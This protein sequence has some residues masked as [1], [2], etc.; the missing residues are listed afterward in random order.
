[1]FI[2]KLIPIYWRLLLRNYLIT[3]VFF[4]AG[5]IALFFLLSAKDLLL[6]ISHGGSL[7]DNFLFALYQIPLALP[8]S[9]PFSF[10][11]SS[12]MVVYKGIDS[13][14]F[15]AFRSLGLSFTK[16]FAPL[17]VLFAFVFLCSLLL[18]SEA[19]PMA[20]E[21]SKKMVYENT[22]KYPLLM[23][24]RKD[25]LIY[26]DLNI[27]LEN[28]GQNRAKDLLV[29]HRDPKKNRLTLFQ[30]KK[31]TTD[32]KS[33]SGEN[34]SVISYLL[35]ENSPPMLF[36]ENEQKMGIDKAAFSKKLQKSKM[37]KSLS[38]LPMRSLLIK[39]KAD[40]C[41]IFSINLEIMYRFSLAL[42]A[43]SF[44]L[45]GL[46]TSLFPFKRQCFIVASLC[47]ITLLTHFCAKHVSHNLFICA[48]F[49]FI[50]SLSL[51]LYSSYSFWKNSRRFG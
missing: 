36:I 32:E 13:Q 9:L 48:I 35:K 45:L 19:A 33:L 15:T 5:F 10:L 28:E 51:I 11:F 47:F 31:L 21:K 24:K 38:T 8:L 3:F 17:F 27:S 34:L 14:E 46:T 23:L 37:K 18:V 39:K 22:S 6:F 44:A 7:F 4:Q 2:K 49:Y 42:I 43:T 1:M 40:P 16:L 30:A 20:V 41:K 26:P 12:I 25:L 50:P 29:A